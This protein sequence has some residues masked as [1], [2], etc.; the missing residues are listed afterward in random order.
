[1]T[2]RA[3]TVP[4][5]VAADELVRVVTE[6]LTAVGVGR[7]DAEVVADVLVTADLG[8]I[9][10][11]GVSR[12][13]RYVDGIRRGTIA[14]DNR[15]SIVREGPTTA[16]LDAGNG[17]GQPAMTRAVGLAIDKAREYGTAAVTVRRSN[18]FGVAG[19][20][21]RLGARAGLLTIVTTN[22]TPQVAPTNG[23]ERMLG[24][25]PLAIALPT[26]VD[27]PFV[28]D[29]ATSVVPRGRLERMAGRGVGDI[30][31]GWVID[32]EGRP[33]T[34][35]RDILA[36]LRLPDRHAMLPLGGA[37]EDFGGHK[38][39]GL[40]MIADL[41]CGPLAG[42]RWGRHVYGSDGAGLGH[43]VLCV[44][45][46]HLTTPAEFRSE[47]ARMFA[48]IRGTRPATGAP[49]VRIA[50]DQE[51]ASRRHGRRYGI[52]LDADVAAA[53]AALAGDLEVDPP[54]RVRAPDE[55]QP[56]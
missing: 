15:T 41:L 35:L 50:G 2:T 31:A 40:G 47:A 3:D 46:G 52:P 10:S 21:A 20:Y 36:G 56:T 6:C 26:A 22:A 54:R 34:D 32:G 37:G 48:E 55:E 9:D 45:V 53:V 19:Y 23:A 18:H 1:M 27:E 42:A 30:G 33:A 7:A 38:G 12:L 49:S 25:N 11:H 43:F 29:A 44:D 51:R 24:T 16:V 14:A 28:F 8:G 4:I 17:L 39:F 13:R 5:T